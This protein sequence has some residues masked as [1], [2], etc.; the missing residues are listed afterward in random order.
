LPDGGAVS[1]GAPTT[2]SGIGVLLPLM[3]ATWTILLGPVGVTFVT[4]LTIFELP[5]VS[6]R[7]NWTVAFGSMPVMSKSGALL[8]LLKL[9]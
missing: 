4:M 1:G 8:L 3:S 7:I 6:V 9:V 5:F 2:L